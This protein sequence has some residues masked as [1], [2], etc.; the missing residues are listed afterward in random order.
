MER[1]QFGDSGKTVVI[2]EFL[3]GKEVSVHAFLDGEHAVMFPIARDHKQ[4]G[5]GNTGPN[6]GG[7]GTIAPLDVP[8]GFID[9]VK[10]RVVMPVVHGMKEAGTPFRGILFPG[11]IHRKFQQAELL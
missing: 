7:M 10:K 3:Q 9:E 2:E 4:I 1:S 6:T 11:L 8:E 5:E